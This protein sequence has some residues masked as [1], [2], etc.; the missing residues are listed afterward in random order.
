MSE[1]FRQVER[2]RGIDPRQDVPS[3]LLPQ[4]EVDSLTR[5][6]L[7]LDWPLV[8]LQREELVL[9]RFGLSEPGMVLDDLIVAMHL[10]TSIVAPTADNRLAISVGVRQDDKDRVQIASAYERLLLKQAY[11]EADLAAQAQVCLVDVDGCLA[12]RA[13]FAGDT[14]LLAEQWLRTFGTAS[15][16]PGD[17][18]LPGASQPAAQA[19]S[20]ALVPVLTFPQVYGLE[21]ARTLFLK[22]GWVGVDQ[23][24]ASP[25]ISTEQILHPERYPKDTPRPPVY[26]DPAPTLGEGWRTEDSGVLGE[27]RTRLVLQAYLDPDEAIVAAQGWDGDL[28][29][30]LR[31]DRLGSSCFVL[32]TRWDTV[33]DAHEFS[34]AFRTYGESRF[35]PTRRVGTTLTWTTPSGIVILDVGN[36]QTLWIEAPDEIVASALR[37]VT[38]FPLY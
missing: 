25:P 16:A 20:S 13:L 18:P 15:P 5:E 4:A 6:A 28:Y 26:P 33:R 23:A 27:W 1:I 32:L 8:S 2:L 38:G 11:A 19:A 29:A 36:D 17:V 35:G 10:D 31:D 21:F 12:R 3:A 37:E 22:A 7:L 24:Y 30:L 34:A 14:A 9:Q